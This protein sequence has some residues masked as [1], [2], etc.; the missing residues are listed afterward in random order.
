[1]APIINATVADPAA[2]S[3]CTHDE[4]DAYFDSRLPIVPPWVASG[5][6]VAL[7]MACR[8]LESS[9]FPSKLFVPASGGHDAYY[10]QRRT[11]TGLPATT[12]QKLA[13]PRTGMVDRNGN[14]IPSNVIPQELK[15]AQSEFAGQLLK[16]DRTLDNDV[17]VQG[18]TSLR[19][20]PVSLSFKQ[21]GIFAQVIPDAVLN[22]IPPSWLTDE[23]ITPAYGAEFDVV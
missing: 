8:S 15:D 5:E 3:Y 23:I 19:A 11:W 13:W 9:L 21:D 7:V 16:T 2:N 14:E 22:L 12:T 4:A 6:A 17:I 10:R 20:G 1:M 18:I